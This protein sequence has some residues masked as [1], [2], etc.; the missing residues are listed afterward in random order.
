MIVTARNGLLRYAMRD[1]VRVTGFHAETPIIS[2]V[3][4]EGRFINSVGEKVTEEQLV[5]AIQGVNGP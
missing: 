3:G 2:F 4:K 5:L 1:R